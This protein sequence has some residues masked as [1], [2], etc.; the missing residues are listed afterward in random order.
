MNV[1]DAA[2][3]L[4]VGQAKVVLESSEH[5]ACQ[6]K[7]QEKFETILVVRHRSWTLM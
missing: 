1:D 3:C 6:V 7:I 4:S 5:V 2:T